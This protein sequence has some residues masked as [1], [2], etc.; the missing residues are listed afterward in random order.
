MVLVGC[1]GGEPHPQVERARVS[2]DWKT[3]RTEGGPRRVE[4]RRRRVVSSS[5]P[6]SPCCPHRHA[7]AL[8]PDRCRHPAGRRS[9]PAA[10]GSLPVTPRAPTSSALCASGS[11]SSGSASH[12]RPDR[13]LE[14]AHS[15]LRPTAKKLGMKMV[16]R[17]VA[18]SIRSKAPSHRQRSSAVTTPVASMASRAAHIGGRTPGGGFRIE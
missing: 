6:S 11:A 16:A 5:T 9:C 12:P 1:S 14:G 10:G 7:N 18:V 17:T 15:D 13:P 3:F 4:G 8:S 2:V